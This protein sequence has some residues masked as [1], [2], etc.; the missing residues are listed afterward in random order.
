AFPPAPGSD[1]G[2]RR[3]LSQYRGELRIGVRVTA[4]FAA[5]AAHSLLPL[6][7]TF[8]SPTA[9]RLPPTST[10]TASARSS[11]G[12]WMARCE[13]TSSRRTTAAQMLCAH[14][15]REHRDNPLMFYR[16]YLLPIAELERRRGHPEN[17]RDL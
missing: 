8:L 4:T 12:S 7:P 13:S 5:R 6:A 10:E 17:R 9:R 14:S 3:L 11:S 16:G 15:K 2:M 1:K